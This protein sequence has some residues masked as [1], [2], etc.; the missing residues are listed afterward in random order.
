MASYR[1]VLTSSAERE[2]AG[3]DKP[4]IPVLW[5]KIKALATEPRPRQSKKLKGTEKSYRLRYRDYRIVYTIDD[6]E[7]LV[8][9]M[10]VRHRKDAYR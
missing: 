5:E 9:V 4:A 3:L 10:A 1:V 8:T 7:G 2:L 6:S